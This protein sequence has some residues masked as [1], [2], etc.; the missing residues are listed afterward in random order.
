MFKFYSPVVVFMR[1]V[2]LLCLAVIVMPF[3]LISNKTAQMGSLFHRAWVKNGDKP[4]WLQCQ[5][6]AS[7][8]I[9]F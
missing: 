4:V 9:Q 2:I 1:R 7:G 6:K 3:A 8:S 5:E